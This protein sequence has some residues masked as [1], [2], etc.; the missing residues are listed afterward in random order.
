MA[1]EKGLVL[2]AGE[3]WAIVLLPGGDYKRVRTRERLQTGQLYQLKSSAALKYASVAAVF[4]L[5][6]LTSLDFFTVTAR[7]N[8]SPGINLGLNRWDRVVSVRTSN[9]DAK[10]E[11]KDLSLNGKSLNQAINMIVERRGSEPGLAAGDKG[12][13]N[14]VS[15]SLS[16]KNQK[17]K[18]REER[19]LK[20][21]DTTLKESVAGQQ[22]RPSAAKV[23][24]KGNQL[25][26]IDEHPPGQTSKTPGNSAPKGEKNKPEPKLQEHK[27]NQLLLDQPKKKEGGG[28][29]EFKDN[30]F[31]ADP[32]KGHNEKRD[33]GLPASALPK[34]QKMD[35]QNSSKGGGR[36][37]EPQEKTKTEKDSGPKHQKKGN[38]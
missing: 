9:T 14:Q 32:E 23:I 4:I 13:N 21:I 33:N 30:N 34:D 26:V 5:I 28:N 35:S 20:I 1:K 27:V 22:G 36:S 10:A 16:V 12:E 37:A 24:R 25:I 11:V 38:S 18:Q 6:T 15:V 2:E 3:G 29:P 17:D 19:L 7:A 31:M 8:V